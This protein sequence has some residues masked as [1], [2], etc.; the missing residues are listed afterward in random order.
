MSAR[1]LCNRELAYA[2]ELLDLGDSPAIR[3]AAC[4]QLWSALRF[5]WQEI[6]DSHDVI[7]VGG[8]HGL[9]QL[10]SALQ[11]KFGE[12]HPVSE[13]TQL[14]ESPLVDELVRRC[15]PA[16]ALLELSR[17]SRKKLEHNIIKTSQDTEN[18]ELN[19]E[20]FERDALDFLIRVIGEWR[21]Y[22][23]EY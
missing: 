20:S 17:N 9:G 15:D 1:G 2:R 10:K 21:E 22:S 7:H 12:D 16:S 23:Q 5:F 3:S 11:S 19:L 6:A 14:E 4:L 13:L 8:F 18:K